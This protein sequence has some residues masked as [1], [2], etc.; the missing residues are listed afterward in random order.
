[1][2]L[3]DALRER[4]PAIVKQW[5]EAVVATYHE[6]T[7]E[8]LRRTKAQFANPAGFNI[9]EGLD[10]LFDAV[11]QEVLPESVATS[12]DVIVRLRAIQDFAP[13]QALAFVFQLK[14][15]IRDALGPEL[16]DNAA[17]RAELAVVDGVID[18]LALYA[19]DLYMR[20][21]EKI[22]DLKAQEARDMTFRLLQKAQAI[23]DK[24]E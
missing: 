19:F 3:K 13:S 9:A 8:P 18:D 14:K 6:E 22:Y 7:R 23:A 12:L 2:N 10:G 4:K 5:F 17:M 20:C 24:Q 11:L 1:M 15:I 16:T 21:R